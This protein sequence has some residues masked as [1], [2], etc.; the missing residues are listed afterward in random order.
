MHRAKDDPSTVVVYE[1]WASPDAMAAHHRSEHM[2]LFRKTVR[3]LVEWPP[4]AE[5]L[6]PES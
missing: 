3:S 5:L 6:T 4:K 1:S 2:D